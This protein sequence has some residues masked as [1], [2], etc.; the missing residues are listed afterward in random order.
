MAAWNREIIFPYLCLV[1]K[2]LSAS[3]GYRDIL[4][5]RG[6]RGGVSCVNVVYGGWVVSN[7]WYK[8]ASNRQLY[9]L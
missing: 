6:Q 1:L 9:V 8:Y 5:G 3:F 4:T 7:I 2:H